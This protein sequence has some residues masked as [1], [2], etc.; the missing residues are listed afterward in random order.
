MEKVV[1]QDCHLVVDQTQPISQ[2][3]RWFCC[4]TTL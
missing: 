1:V 4:F 2:P 3:N